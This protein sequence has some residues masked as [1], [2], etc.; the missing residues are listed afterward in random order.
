MTQTNADYHADTS[1]VGSSM[2]AVFRASPELY[3]AYYVHK[4]AAREETPQMLLGTLVHCMALEPD[5]F[6]DRFAIAPKVDR[7]TKA[8]KAEWS[9]FVEESAGLQVVD[10][11]M[12]AAATKM[13]AAIWSSPAVHRLADVGGGDPIYEQPLQFSWRGIDCKAKPD[14]RTS[15]LVVDIKTAIDPTP[16]AFVRSVVR[17]GYHRQAAF[18][19]QACNEAVGLEDRAFVWIAV[20]NSEP[21]DVFVYEAS[22]DDLAIGAQQAEDSL[23]RLARC[24]ESGV[25]HHP[26]HDQIT[27]LTLPAWAHREEYAV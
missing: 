3:A 18:Y 20:R 7:R 8:G 14:W 5:T 1:R 4:T 24:Y 27:R 16:D 25:W 17:F 22:P 12:A 10:A 2:L 23:D 21:W 11:E 13:A 26:L 6:R 9:T 15:G 19:L